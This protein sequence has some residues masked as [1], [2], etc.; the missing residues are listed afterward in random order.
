MALKRSKIIY[1]ER[2]G[3]LIGGAMCCAAA[4]LKAQEALQTA[5]QEDRSFE[6]RNAPTYIPKATGLSMGP[7][8]LSVSASY[9]VQ[10]DD[11]IR[12]TSASP[13]T[14]RQ[15]DYIHT[16]MVMLRSIWPVTD[17]SSLS[18][19]AGIGYSKYTIHSDLDRVDMTPDSEIAW[20]IRWD[21]C[22]L[23]VHDRI[24]YSQDV[25][26]QPGL[27]GTAEYPRLENTGGLRLQYS[28]EYYTAEIGYDHYNF[29]PG[30]ST[31]RYL[32][33][34]SEQ[35]FGRAA[36]R[37]AQIS[38]V[39]LEA[40]GS[41]TDYAQD[42]QGDNESISIGPFVDWQVTDNLR[43][44]ARGGYS[45][46]YLDAHPVAT[47]P[48]GFSP[49]S[50]TDSYYV[51]FDLRHKLTD[52][53]THG[54][55]VSRASQQAVNQ[56]G[57]IAE[58]FRAAYDLSWNFSGNATAAASFFYEEGTEP[59]LKSSET[60]KRFGV[61]PTISYH[62]TSHVDLSLAYNYVT[63]DSNLTLRDYY[64]NTV[65]LSASYRF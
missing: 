43:I 25:I 62:A 26:S 63:K 64:Q 61:S 9:S 12:L 59:Q 33:R 55:S 60:Y 18:F 6:A 17:T 10:W 58:A 35:F 37:L 8:Q 22:V 28:P 20:D 5:V 14:K 51:G 2:L 30:G 45:I 48:P 47:V 3:I 46:Y 29:V 49:S 34:Q 44:T 36:Y 52:F 42:A 13:T 32:K 21:D 41:L 65:T 19:G 4:S 23:N 50:K 40:S 16:P 38:R 57:G 56:G 11:N 1:S 31:Y 24:N 53:I 15:E 39:G 27:S 54:V 7:V